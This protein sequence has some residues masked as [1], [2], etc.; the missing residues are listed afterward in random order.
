MVELRAKIYFMIS[1]NQTNVHFV[2]NLKVIHPHCI[3]S[4][5]GKTIYSRGT[6]LS[7]CATSR[8]VAGSNPDGVTEV[9]HLHN[10]YG[11]GVDSA[12]NRNE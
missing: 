4:I 7:H 9:L 8:E 6:R 10:H 1:K 2:I 11:P 5:T 12:S 3:Y